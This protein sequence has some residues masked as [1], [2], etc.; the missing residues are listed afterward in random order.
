LTNTSDNI[1]LALLA[2][3][4]EAFDRTSW[5]GPNLRGSLR[6]VTARQAAWKPGKDRK[7]IWEQALHTA[8]WKYVV[9]RRILG[10]KRGSFPLEGSNWFPVPPGAN[11]KLWRNHLALL[12]DEH[13]QLR[14]AIA[15]LSP[16]DLPR[17]PKKSKVSNA[18][19]IRGVAAH[20]LYHAGQINLLKRLH[21]VKRRA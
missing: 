4:D 6:G 13:K 15:M 7:G 5:H 21:G 18:M 12:E 10:E 9:R 17:K 16:A 3:I 1:V 2:S 11:E 14:A 8:Y 20:D 19:I